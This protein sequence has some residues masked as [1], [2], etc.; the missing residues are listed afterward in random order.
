MHQ[1]IASN[2]ANEAIGKGE[3]GGEEGLESEKKKALCT[4]Y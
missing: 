2:Q 4:G 1:E 3:G